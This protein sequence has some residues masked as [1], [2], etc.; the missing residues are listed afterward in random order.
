MQPNNTLPDDIEH[1]WLN[2]TND[3]S[4]TEDTKPGQTIQN[5]LNLKNLKLNTV[6]Q[7]STW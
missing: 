1:G 6:E 3:M 7:Y 4:I 2:N 5:L